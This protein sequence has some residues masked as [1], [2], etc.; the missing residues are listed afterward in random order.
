M[1]IA[2]W[3]ILSFLC[4]LSPA[5]G[6]SGNPAPPY[7]EYSDLVNGPPAG[8][9]DSLGAI[10]TLFGAAF[11][12]SQGDS[13]VTLADMPVRHVLQWSDRKIIFQ[14][15]RTAKSGEL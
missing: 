7:L 13:S 6:E 12:K 14:I 8:G 3:W 9:P 15:D 5:F 2:L 11:G 4:T 1:K 10:V